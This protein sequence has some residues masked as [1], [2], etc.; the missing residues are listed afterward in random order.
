MSEHGVRGPALRALTATAGALALLPCATPV[1]AQPA[2]VEEVVVTA[3]KRE[4]RLLETPVAVSAVTAKD[5]ESLGLANLN[6]ITKATPGFFISNYGTQRN[7]RATQVLTIREKAYVEVAR[8]N[9]EGPWEI[10]FREVMPNLMPYI[11]ASFVGTVSG[12]ILAVIGLEALGLGALE[13]MT[14]GNTIY[15]SQ[16]SAAVLRGYWWWWGPPIVMIAL[17]F[18]GLFLT[19]VGFDRFANPRLARR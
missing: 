1:R 16:Q 17:I 13:E 14:L 18:I 5:I 9:G 11:V 15:W 10:L 2:A 19:S 3:R 4:E 7:D 8:V 6:D 12:S